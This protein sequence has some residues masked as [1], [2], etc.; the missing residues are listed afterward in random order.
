MKTFAPSVYTPTKN[1]DLARKRQKQ[2]MKK[3]IKY[4][5]LSKEETN[6]IMN[7]KP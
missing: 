3:M 2:V 4:D 1:P 5:Y 6:Y 7:Q